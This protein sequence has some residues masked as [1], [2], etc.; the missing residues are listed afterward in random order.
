MM[1]RFGGFFGR[2][3]VRGTAL[4]EVSILLT[5]VSVF[6]QAQSTP[7]WR[8][9]LD[10]AVKPP[11]NSAASLGKVT[12]L[13]VLSDGSLYVAEE[14]PARVSLFG[15]TGSLVRVM[16]RQGGGPGEVRSPAITA[17]GDTLVVY[18]ASLGRVTRMAPNGHV[19]DEH[20]VIGSPMGQVWA[21]NDGQIIVS[22][23]QSLASSEGRA[24]R[25]RN[26][27][28]DTVR[29]SH[30]RS[31][32]LWIFWNVPGVDL[33]G[34]I[35]FSP[36]GIATVDPSGRVV[37]GGSRRSRWVVV[38]GSDT[39]QTVTLPDTPVP[40]AKR[41]RD[42]VW[43][44]YHAQLSRK[45]IPRLD[46]FVREERIPTTLPP[47]VTFDI[48]KSGAWWIGRP[49]P[50]GVLAAWDVVIDGRLVGHATLPAKGVDVN[51][52]GP[53]RSFGKEFIALLHEDADG[54]PW[55]GVYRVVEGT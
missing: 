20:E 29:W 42:S 6:V 26:G 40:I 10:H 17:Q 46:E 32:D 18:D 23:A 54:L 35:P 15:K 52:A 37:I 47:W 27:R 48:D 11:E 41:I 34:W 3:S 25:L 13:A 9:E 51:L 19:V 7:R 49:G 22:L 2:S 4:F 31:E 33:V 38:S 39:L 21:A 24:L 44:A 1:H 43:A 16:M 28:I 5:T 55:I 8:L 12:G 53:L 14:T 36:P 45:R 30:P 50:D